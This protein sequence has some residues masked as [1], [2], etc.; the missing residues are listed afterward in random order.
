VEN[1]PL[2]GRPQVAQGGLGGGGGPSV[3]RQQAGRELPATVPTP[4][5]PAADPPSTE[6][7]EPTASAESAAP[8]S[9][10]EADVSPSSTPQAQGQRSAGKSHDND[11]S[12]LL[13]SG[14]ALLFGGLVAAIVAATV[15]AAA[16]I[17]VVRN[18]TGRHHG[19]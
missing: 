18:P 13:T 7:P 17:S 12:T 2:V 8:A 11:P 1:S 4:T 5:Q 19:Q 14:P 16:A 15:L 10:E 6:L 9:P 3:T